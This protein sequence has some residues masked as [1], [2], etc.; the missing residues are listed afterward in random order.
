M[1]SGAHRRQEKTMTELSDLKDQIEECREELSNIAWEISSL[2]S[3]MFED[4]R[5]KIDCIEL[6]TDKL[7]DRV[8]EFVQQL[9]KLVEL[10]DE[11]DAERNP[12]TADAA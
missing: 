9:D 11:P 7:A 5:D 1:A 12:A 3:S 4:V 2:R 10:V 6:E 8:N